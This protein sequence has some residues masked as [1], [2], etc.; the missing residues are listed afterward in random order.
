[1]DQL[2]PQIPVY[3]ETGSK[4]TF[5]GAI[6]WPGWC[7]SA[8]DEESSLQKLL[9][10]APRYQRALEGGPVAFNVMQGFSGFS[11]VERLKGNATTDF[12]APAVAPAADS[13]PL[14]EPELQRYEAILTGCW[15]A[16]DA[17]AKMAAGKELVKGPRGGGR[18][19]HQIVEHVLEAEMAYLSRLGWEA[20]QPP[21][22]EPKEPSQIREAILRSVRVAAGNR[23]HQGPR[24]GARWTPR[25]FVRRVAWHALDHA[26]EI[27]D[28]V[29]ASTS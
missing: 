23:P 16:L 22:A 4:R 11:V 13:R 14:D 8:R 7:R 3:I 20:G 25:Y 26:W 15:N 5:A 6:E 29:I 9:D 17:S 28:R 10:Y 1:M 24:G 12:G 21:T 19:L 2:A 18:D 27:E